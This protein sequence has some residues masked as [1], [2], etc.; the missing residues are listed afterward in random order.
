MSVYYHNNIHPSF[1]FREAILFPFSVF[2][3]VLTRF[4]GFPFLLGSGGGRWG[5][6]VEFHGSVGLCPPPLMQ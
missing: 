1:K 4:C 5:G 2:F 6:A 3:P